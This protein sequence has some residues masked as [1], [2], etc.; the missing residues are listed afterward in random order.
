VITIIGLGAIGRAIGLAL[1]A[2]RTSF[3]VVGHDP[4]PELTR[5][6]KESGAVDRVHWDLAGVTQSADLIIF[7]APLEATLHDLELVGPIVREGALLTD[8]CP[9]KVPVM[10]MAA[11]VVRNDA[12]WVGGHLVANPDPDR[13][14]ESLKGATWCLVPSPDADASSV[15]VMSRLVRAVGADP[16]F[17]GAEEH[18]ALGTGVF[19]LGYLM[20]SAMLNLFTASPSMRDLRRLA[21]P[22][23]AALGSDS[24][25][26]GDGTLL[27]TGGLS[28]AVWIDGLL[29]E[30]ARAREAAVSS[31]EAWA[32]YLDGLKLAREAWAAARAGDEAE[33]AAAFD[34]LE[35][36]NVLRDGLLGRRRR[37]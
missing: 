20:S 3:E 26:E 4:D 32:G 29:R 27:R 19:G 22:G 31:P 6:A 34:E 15:E 10:E 2:V 7:A 1:Q 9:V 23:I 35:Q 13:P 36:T 11:R 24:S 8:V 14:A 12:S 37:R 25:A 18:D 5:L 30:L 16:Y 21:P 28:A 17:I 33:R